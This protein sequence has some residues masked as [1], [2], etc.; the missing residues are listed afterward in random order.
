LS[1]VTFRWQTKWWLHAAAGTDNGKVF[2]LYN[3]GYR[4]YHPGHG[5]SSTATRSARKAAS[6]CTPTSAMTR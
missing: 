6:I 3:F 4:W 5:A 2:D 1:K